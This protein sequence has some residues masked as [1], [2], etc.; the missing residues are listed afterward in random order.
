MV[1]RRAATNPPALLHGPTDGLCLAFANTKYWRGA[2]TPTEELHGPA[3]LLGWCE[4][5]AI[6]D[7]ETLRRLRGQWDR[8]PAEA[9]AG[10]AD[11]VAIR[12]AIF[13]IFAA[14]A[15]GDAPAAADLAAFNAAL[16]AAPE[17]SSLR[18]S[19]DAYRWEVPDPELGPGLLLAPV[20][21]SAGDLLSGARLAQVRRC[22][23]ERCLWLFVDESKSGNRR[24]CSMASCGNR[25]K[26]HR[27]YLRSKQPG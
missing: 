1:T 15:A 3:D 7:P 11:A 19:D 23:N 24:W 21:W 2:P 25:A 8:A 18:R 22:A 16:R 12:E 13:R 6:L 10:F 14:N 5:A 20:L 27:H 4:S 17:R 9:A 26:A